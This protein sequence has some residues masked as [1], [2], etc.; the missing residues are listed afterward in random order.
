VPRVRIR[1]ECPHCDIALTLHLHAARVAL[2]LLRS[3]RARRRAVPV[4]GDAAAL[5][6]AGTQRAERELRRAAR[7]AAAAARHRRRA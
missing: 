2:P 7:G 4:R 1:A 5:S 6:G 3:S